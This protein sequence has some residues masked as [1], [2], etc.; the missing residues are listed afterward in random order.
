MNRKRSVLLVLLLVLIA[1]CAT[2]PVAPA[3]E[4]TAYQKAQLRYVYLEGLYAAQLKDTA[5]M[6]AM[7]QAGSLSVEQT[8]IY[9][10]KKAALIKV[11]PLLEAYDRILLNGG[12]PSS[13]RD[14]EITDILNELAAAAGST[15]EL[16][17]QMKLVSS[18]CARRTDEQFA[19]E[20]AALTGRSIQWR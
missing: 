10:I 12:I 13:D 9:R 11:K 3:P 20:I 17:R 8:R 18:E 15:T 2:A 1:G 6:G 7:A 4:Q 5:S 16:K 14:K 19:A